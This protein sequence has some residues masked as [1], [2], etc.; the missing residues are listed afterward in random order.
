[1]R[2]AAGSAAPRKAALRCRV[3]HKP[4]QA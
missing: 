3:R 4:A 2:G 1:L